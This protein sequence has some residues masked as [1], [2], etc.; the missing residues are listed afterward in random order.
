[1]TA[2]EAAPCRGAIEWWFKRQVGEPFQVEVQFSGDCYNGSWS[3]SRSRG[4]SVGVGRGAIPSRGTI[5][6]PYPMNP[7]SCISPTS[8]FFS[9]NISR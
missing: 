1:M 7:L 6:R 3:R 2:G 5:V 4:D 8:F 9:I